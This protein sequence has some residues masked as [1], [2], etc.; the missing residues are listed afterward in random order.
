LHLLRSEYPEMSEAKAEK[1]NLSGNLTKI[2]ILIVLGTGLVYYFS[3]PRPQSYYDYTFRVAERFFHGEVGLRQRPPSW[4]N[5]FVP[6]EGSYYS[7]FPYGSVLSMVPFA[8]F[9]FIGVTEDMPA[10]LIGGFLAGLICLLLFLISRYYEHTPQKRIM[11]V[12]GIMFGTWL[13]TNLMMAG[14][15]H[16]ALG[17]AMAGELGAIYFI[18]FRRN[19]VLAGACFALAFGNRTEILLTAPIFMFMLASEKVY[20]LAKEHAE[21][22]GRELPERN[23]VWTDLTG[24]CF[25]PFLL[26]IS[27]LVYNYA[28]FHS[29]LDFGYARIPGVL[30]EPWYRHGIFSIWYIPYNINEM[31]LMTWKKVEGFPYYTPTGF[32][33]SVFMASPFLIFIFTRQFKHDILKYICWTAIVVQTFLLWIHGNAGGWQFSYRYA[34]ILLPWIFLI[35][36]ETRPKKITVLEW[37]LYIFSFIINLYATY[38]F[39]WTDYVKP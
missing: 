3:N 32:G 23:S 34:I 8:F 33:G 20:D 5:E 39:F 25:V 27:T 26:G 14:A 35:L 22:D 2:I 31:L 36:L 13:W 37:I 16:L 30:N 4:L 29:P 21:P 28:R 7:V 18:I 9:K 1:T 15:W 6:F 11:L 12:L 24:F 17:F 19:A 38:L 10:G